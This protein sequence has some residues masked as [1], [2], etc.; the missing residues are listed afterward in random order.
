MVV[1]VDQS[2][3]HER[4]LQIE[5]SI[6]RLGRRIERKHAGG[7]ANR[8]CE[9]GGGDDLGVGEGERTKDGR[10]KTEEGQQTV[11][12]RRMTEEKLPSRKAIYRRPSSVVGRHFMTSGK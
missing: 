10:R 4:T 3:K 12:R 2:G 11:D 8:F 1:G 9:A 7:E 6:L 5:D